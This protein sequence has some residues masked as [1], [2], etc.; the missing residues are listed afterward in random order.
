MALKWLLSPWWRCV[1]HGGGLSCPGCLG[2]SSVLGR[3]VR[4]SV[5][6]CSWQSPGDI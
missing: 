6:F 1:G 5:L 2:R 3:Q 4:G